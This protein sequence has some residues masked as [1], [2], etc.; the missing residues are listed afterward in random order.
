MCL[1]IKKWLL[2]Q[3]GIH[4]LFSLAPFKLIHDRNGNADLAHR[5]EER[6]QRLCIGNRHRQQDN[7][8]AHD[9]DLGNAP[10]EKKHAQGKVQDPDN[11]A[12]NGVQ[13]VSALIGMQF[14]LVYHGIAVRSESELGIL[15]QTKPD[16]GTDNGNG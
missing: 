4:F 9:N 11:E 10:Q 1:N 16:G 7:R 12:K 15:N 6:G 14:P 5:V 8:A 13:D 2:I 3:V